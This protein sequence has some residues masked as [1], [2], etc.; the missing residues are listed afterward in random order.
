M[1]FFGVFVG[2]QKDNHNLCRGP[3]KKGHAQSAHCNYIGPDLAPRTLGKHK[4]KG[5]TAFFF[6]PQSGGF[7]KLRVGASKS[8]LRKKRV[9][10][11]GAVVVCLEMGVAQK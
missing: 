1:S 5:V 7:G 3:P 4:G 11:L 10:K 2:N 9:G 8:G 6:E